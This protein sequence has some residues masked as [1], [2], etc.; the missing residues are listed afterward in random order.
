MARLPVIV[1]GVDVDAAPG[2][3]IYVNDEWFPVFVGLLERGLVPG[4]WGGVNGEQI[5]RD[6]VLSIIASTGMC[7]SMSQTAII[8]DE[9]ASGVQSGN[10]NAG[11]NL[12]PL[13]T[14][15]SNGTLSIISLENNFFVLPLGVYRV[16]AAAAAMLNGNARLRL[17]DSTGTLHYL[18]GLNNRSELET[19]AGMNLFLDVLVKQWDYHAWGLYHYSQYLKTSNGMGSHISNGHPEVYAT[20]TITRIGDL[21]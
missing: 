2:T 6:A 9:R 20:V 1:P 3:C 19:G 21:P 17:T 14:V 13:N 7:G 8:R 11:W 4:Y 12:R 18:S 16:Q 15:A 10:V 5:G